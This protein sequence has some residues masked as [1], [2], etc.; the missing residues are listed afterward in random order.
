MKVK[1]KTFSMFLLL[2][3]L[4]LA[5][6]SGSKGS[7]GATGAPGATGTAGPAGPTM[8]VIQDTIA[9]GLPA[10]PGSSITAVV[11]AQSAQNL[12]L[13]YSWSTSSGWAIKGGGTSP[14]VTIKAVGGYDAIGYAMVTVSDTQSRAATGVVILNTLYGTWGYA[15]II[16]AGANN[17]YAPQVSFDS[18]GNASAVWEQYDGTHY[19]IYAN[20]Y[21]AGIGWGSAAT[22]DAGA[23]N[24]YN[25]QVSFDS[26]GN[27]IAVWRQWDG[28][29][30]RIYANRY[31]AGT[32][33][34]SAGIIDAGANNASLPQ[35]SFDSAGN[36]I[37]VWQQSDG[38]YN[39]I[40]ANRYVAG[41]GWGSAVAIETNPNDAADPQVSFD[42]A[43]NAIAVWYQS[44][45]NYSRIYSNRYV[46]GTGWGAAT[47]IETDANDAYNPQVSFDSAG[48][49]IA[50]WYQ[51]DGTYNRIYSNRYVAGTGWGLAAAIETNA[52]TAS[53]PQVSFDSAGN[54]ISVWQQSDS[55][56]NRIYANRFQ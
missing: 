52:N 36:A 4:L 38:T 35:V 32:G 26:A 50:V 1:I 3:M 2:V 14:T 30:Y 18:A 51:S 45:G 16:D 8:P 21:V 25:P 11:L 20:R 44:D 24:A 55:T 9:Y 48:N 7:T 12:A 28:S 19:R 6:C 54:A 23:N 43:G 5:G 17:A 34:G 49:A 33:W 39:R 15:A 47:A 46:A 40:Y 42:S 22:I 13:T 10:L 41:T 29:N 53:D 56:Y 37:S 31:V 27:A